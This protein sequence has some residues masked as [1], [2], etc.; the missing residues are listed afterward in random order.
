MQLHVSVAKNSIHNV[1]K[2]T[3]KVQ[4]LL[5]FVNEQSS[6]SSLYV[7]FYANF[8]LTCSSAI[9]I[10]H[11]IPSSHVCASFLHRAAYIMTFCSMFSWL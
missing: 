4:I 2:Y 9:F 8:I 11:L 1:V 5:N 10:Q 6:F 7:H 3:S